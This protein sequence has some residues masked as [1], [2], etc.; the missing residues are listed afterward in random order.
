MKI[1]NETMQIEMQK[2]NEIVSQLVA[3]CSSA[4]PLGSFRS[5][6]GSWNPPPGPS[7]RGADDNIQMTT[8]SL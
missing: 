7:R 5:Q 6:H 2:L 4:P 1:D 3:E 8:L